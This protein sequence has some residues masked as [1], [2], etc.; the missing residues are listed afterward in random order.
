MTDDALDEAIAKLKVDL[1][2]TKVCIVQTMMAM[3]NAA[4]EATFGCRKKW[5]NTAIRLLRTQTC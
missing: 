2:E 1:A 5:K 4:D 3:L